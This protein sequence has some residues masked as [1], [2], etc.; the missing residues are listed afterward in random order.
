MRTEGRKPLHDRERWFEIICGIGR[1]ASTPSPLKPSN[2]MYA[3][4]RESGVK[5]V[6]MTRRVRVK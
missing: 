3:E 4:D 5:R 1:K 2:S 6:W